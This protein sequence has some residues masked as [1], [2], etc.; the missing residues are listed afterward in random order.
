LLT[1]LAPA[2]A[3]SAPPT[4]ATPKAAA[5]AAEFAYAIESYKAV[6]VWLALTTAYALPWLE[7]ILGTLLLTAVCLRPAL[8][9]AGALLLSFEVL[10]LSVLIRKIPVASCGCFGSAFAMPPGAEFLTNLF[11]LLIA[12]WL[13]KRGCASVN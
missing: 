3:A 13:W 8:A 12:I 6:P 1:P 5:P 2:R 4:P 9:A 10:I 7:I 11:M